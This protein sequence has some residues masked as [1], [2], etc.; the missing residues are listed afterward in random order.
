ML[1]S[2]REVQTW[3]ALS[4]PACFLTARLPH[5]PPAS[6]LPACLTARLLPHCLPVAQDPTSRVM[7]W[8]PV[9]CDPALST[10]GPAEQAGQEPARLWPR[11]RS[12]TFPWS[13]LEAILQDIVA[14]EGNQRR[15][16]R[17]FFGS[18]A[19]RLNVG[20]SGVLTRGGTCPASNSSSP[21][22]AAP[23]S[24]TAEPLG[25]AAVTAL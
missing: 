14:A 21:E 7:W 23:A 20:A 9:I 4:P 19:Y 11:D 1:C 16:L 24:S 15:Y 5:C 2:A 13:V 6:S 17:R 12:A 22:A 3:N 10:P 8:V 18:G 25:K